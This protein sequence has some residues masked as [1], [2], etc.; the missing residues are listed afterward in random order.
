MTRILCCV[1]ACLL[2]NQ[3]YAYRP[4]T[5]TDAAVAARGEMELECGPVG[6]IVDADG[7]VVLALT[8]LGFTDQLAAD[9]VAPLGQ[10]LVAEAGSVSDALRRSRKESS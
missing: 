1:L 10:R 7:R 8:L 5:S 2:A 4:F 3:A 6:Y 9:D